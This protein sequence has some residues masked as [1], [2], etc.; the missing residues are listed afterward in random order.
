M[1]EFEYTIEYVYNGKREK[2]TGELKD[3]IHYILLEHGPL[4]REELKMATGVPRTTLYDN[5]IKLTFED[6]VVKVSSSYRRPGRPTIGW[7]AL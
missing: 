4:T 2:L 6:R 1:S 7:K 5:L 3:I